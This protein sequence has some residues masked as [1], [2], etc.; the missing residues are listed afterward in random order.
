MSQQELPFF[1]QD[2]AESN[3]TELK[4]GSGGHLP[5]ELWQ[6]ISAF[7]NSEG[8]KLIIGITPDGKRT[9]LN[10]KDLDKLQLDLATLCSS[11]FNVVITPEIL[12]R[13]DV[14]IVDIPPAAAPLR[15][16]YA[17]RQ[18]R[19]KGTY[20]RVGAANY[21]ATEEWHKRVSVAAKGGAEIADYESYSHEDYLDLELVDSF[22]AL[23]NSRR[24]NIYQNFSRKEVLVK[25]K[26]INTKGDATLFGLL[27]FGKDLALQEVVSPTINVGITQYPGSSKVNEDDLSETYLDNRE[28]NGNVLEQFEKAFDFIKTKLPIKGTVDSSGKRRDYFIIPEIALR[29]ALANA[30]AHRD[31][32]SH[33][34]RIQVD[35][36]SDRLEIINP[37]P[38]LVP[39]PELDTAPSSTR[40]PLLMSYLKE[41]GITDQKARGIRTIKISLKKAGLL[42][43][44]LCEHQPLL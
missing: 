37:G 40:N 14:L 20:I 12:C 35:I 25:Q 44:Q 29:E 38:S 3:N 8:G 28:F 41:H 27:A 5:K 39:I 6:T 13:D 11:A 43:P 7:S 2:E 17:K 42:E 22:I 21:V 24:G 23:L 1:V 34:S 9:G 33:A 4:S 36:Y 26:A 19:D 32:S 16:V 15:P 10:V 30:I 31:Y 18:G